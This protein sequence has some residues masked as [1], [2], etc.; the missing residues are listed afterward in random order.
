MAERSQM[1]PCS[2]RYASR[3]HDTKS[4]Q[5]ANKVERRTTVASV[6]N[7]AWG[8]G[9]GGVG[10][11][12]GGGGGLDPLGRAS[13][14]MIPDACLLERIRGEF[15]FES[16]FRVPSV[17]GM[18]FGSGSRFRN[19]KAR[20]SARSRSNIAPFVKTRNAAPT[21]TPRSPQDSLLSAPIRLQRN[22]RDRTI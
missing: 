19:T 8:G 12:G 21:P 18:S 16:S 6:T 3:I 7:F 20:P 2:S 14:I 4:K 1:R 9:G 11:G 5:L 10:G 13:K 17:S 15:F 22:D